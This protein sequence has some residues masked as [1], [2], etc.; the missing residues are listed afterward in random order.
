M[1]DSSAYT[2]T[3][4][5]VRLSTVLYDVPAPVTF[6]VSMFPAPHKKPD[7]VPSLLLYVGSL[8]A[9]FV[10]R[11]PLMACNCP[12]ENVVAKQMYLVPFCRLN[13]VLFLIFDAALP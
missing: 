6:D 4:L 1:D 2:V 9:M 5:A 13:G 8:F 10:P 7:T 11:I 3:L 12:G